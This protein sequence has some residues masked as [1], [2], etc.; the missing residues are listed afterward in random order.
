[1]DQVQKNSNIKCNAPSLERFRKVV[2]SSS[3]G[4]CYLPQAGHHS[5]TFLNYGAH[6]F[7]P[8]FRLHCRSRQIYLSELSEE[9][10]EIVDE[11]D[12]GSANFSIIEY[13][14]MYLINETMC[15]L[16][17]IFF[18][19]NYSSQYRQLMGQAGVEI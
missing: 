8:S 9:F 17:S 19:Y 7:I 6:H 5:D 10:R 18:L 4:A 3:T 14:S 16:L 12:T 2:W 15:G 1:M 13:S 11:T